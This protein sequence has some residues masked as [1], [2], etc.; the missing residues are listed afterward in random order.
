VWVTKVFNDGGTCRGTTP[1]NNEHPGCPL[2]RD[3]SRCPCRCNT[4][5]TFANSEISRLTHG[6]TDGGTIVY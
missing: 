2:A 6:C 5:S 1:A 3:C 4:T